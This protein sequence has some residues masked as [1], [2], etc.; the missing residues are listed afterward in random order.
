MNG[1]HK[2][3]P[4]NFF[5]FV[6]ATFMVAPLS[7]VAMVSFVINSSVKNHILILRKNE[8]YIY[9]HFCLKFGLGVF[10]LYQPKLKL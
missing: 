7:L 10:I 5:Q 6:G 4:Y 8:S 2:G 3:S 1:N 9:T